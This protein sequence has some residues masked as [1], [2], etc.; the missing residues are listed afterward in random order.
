MY[1]NLCWCLI[2]GLYRR[3]LPGFDKDANS[4]EPAAN[5]ETDFVLLQQW[6]RAKQI[7]SKGE[8]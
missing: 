7:E 8:K 4:W 3:N 1:F 6:E 5:F 2:S